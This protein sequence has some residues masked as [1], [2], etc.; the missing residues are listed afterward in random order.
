MNLDTYTER[1]RTVLQAAQG[2]AVKNKNQHFAPEHLLSALLDDESGLAANLI[3]AAGG[4]PE[5][6]LDLTARAL[7]A[8]PKVDGTGQLYLQPQTAEVFT[9]AEDAAKKAGDQFVTAER[10]LQALS[11]VKSTKAEDA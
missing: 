10:L 7:S 1:A 2:L 11:I 3:K 8:L 5:T 6:A 4:R 9:T